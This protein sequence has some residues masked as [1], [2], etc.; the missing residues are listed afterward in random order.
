MSEHTSDRS[1]DGLSEDRLQVDYEVDDE[2]VADEQV[3]DEQVV[4]EQ[5]V[6]EQVDNEQVAEEKVAEEQVANEQVAETQTGEQAPRDPN[7]SPKHERFVGDSA[8][9]VPTAGAESAESS[10]ASTRSDSPLALTRRK[11]KS[12]QEQR[13]EAARKARIDADR[14]STSLESLT[15]TLPNPFTSRTAPLPTGKLA[16]KQVESVAGRGDAVEFVPLAGP[17]VAE[18]ETTNLAAARE[19]QKAENAASKEEKRVLRNTRS[20]SVLDATPSEKPKVSKKPVKG[21]SVK[22]QLRFV[23]L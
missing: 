21:S 12:V 4:D 19:A 23:P 7:V 9:K 1:D 6:D 10:G 22:R 5:V 13:E 8:E 18:E 3:A 14:A 2:Q 20:T 16:H 15:S 11:K 17:F